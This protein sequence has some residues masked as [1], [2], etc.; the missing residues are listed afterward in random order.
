MTK[1]DKSH[2]RY[3]AMNDQSPIF[4]NPIKNRKKITKL[5]LYE[6]KKMDEFH[7]KL[8]VSNLARSDKPLLILVTRNHRATRA[9]ALQ[10]I[11]TIIGGKHIKNITF[12]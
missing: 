11:A 2:C 6:L 8:Y 12:L 5:S 7:F 10:K 1:F 3:F 9:P 4:N